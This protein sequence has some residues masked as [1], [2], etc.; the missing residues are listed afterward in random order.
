[1]QRCAMGSIG[2]QSG[3]VPG[4]WYGTFLNVLPFGLSVAAI[5]RGGER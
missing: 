4:S 1:M 5:E 2:A 3:R